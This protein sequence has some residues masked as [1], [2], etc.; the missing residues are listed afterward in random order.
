MHATSAPSESDLIQWVNTAL[1]QCASV[2]LLARTELAFS[3]LIKPLLVLDEDSPTADERGHAV[4]LLLRW[5]IEHLAPGSPQFPLSGFRPFDDPTW[6]DPRWWSYNILRHRYLEPLHPD[7]FV[8]GGRFTETL[9]ALTGIPSE[10]TFFEERNRAVRSAAQRLLQQVQD[11]AANEELR[12]QALTELYRPLLTHEPARQ[13]LE[14]AAAFEEI[15][16]RTLL[17]DLAKHEH[18]MQAEDALGHLITRRYLLGSAGS[19]W[20]SPILRTFVNSRQNPSQLRLRHQQIAEAYR[21]S[22]DALRATIHLQRAQQWSAAATTL[23]AIPKGQIDDLEV[24]EVIVTLDRFKASHLSKVQWRDVQILLADLCTKNGEIDRAIETC[25]QA[26]KVAEEP[27]QQAR[28]YRRLGKLYE[29]RNQRTAL[30]YYQ[31]AIKHFSIGDLEYLDVLKDRAWLHILRRDWDEAMA[32][33]MLAL[34][35]APESELAIR[36]DIYDAYA[37][38]NRNQKNYRSAIDY[39]QNSLTLR[40]Q[41]GNKLQIAK[42]FNNLGNLYDALGDVP[43]SIAAFQEAVAMAQ[44]LANQPL[45]AEVMLNLGATYFV[46]G[47]VVDSIQNYQQSLTISRQMHLPLIEINAHYNLAEALAT[48]GHTSEAQQHWQTGV[49]LS[50][51]AGFDDRLVYAREVLTQ[52]PELEGGTDSTSAP[53]QTLNVTSLPVVANSPELLP[54]LNLIQ[55]NE[56]ITARDLIDTLHVSKATATRKLASFVAEGKLERRGEGR[57]V[58]YTLP[59]L[60]TQSQTS[61]YPVSNHLQHLLNKLLPSIDAEFQVTSLSPIADSTRGDVAITF[62]HFPDLQ[63]F[64][65]LE[66]KLSDSLGIPINLVLG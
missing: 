63:T 42:S 12:Q 54:I 3:P 35:H 23:L 19:L 4:Q 64:F 65:S 55:R 10:D 2:L 29:K 16:P 30:G 49:T 66:R 15:F 60:Q 53:V 18:V 20:L 38:L 58:Y 26:L 39:A 61:I 8:E 44:L 27:I 32:N 41:I 11:G 28:I 17:I 36:A 51:Q 31:Q 62:K 1:K 24:S 57:G 43:S 50:Q 5:V 37:D 6:R 47:R 34:Q 25:R 7:D 40:E 13:L 33:L 48:L 9:I 21:S 59:Q 45:V 22:G 56:R 46:S 14:I 52:F